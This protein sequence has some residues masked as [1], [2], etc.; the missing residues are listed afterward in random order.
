MKTLRRSVIWLLVSVPLAG[1]GLFLSPS[2]SDAPP[3]AGPVPAFPGSVGQLE[4]VNAP[5]ISDVLEAL[6]PQAT[7]EALLIAAAERIREA[8]PDE[9][10]QVGWFLAPVGESA[11]AWVHITGLEDDSIAGEQLRLGMEGVAGVW[12]VVLVES[13]THCRRGVDEASQLCV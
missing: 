11:G 2:P 10:V 8:R 12:R 7:A 6:P 5:G 1:C 9:E 4:W 13:S 3:R